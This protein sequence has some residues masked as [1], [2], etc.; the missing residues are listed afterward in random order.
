MSVIVMK[1]K[2]WSRHER[3]RRKREWETISVV[4]FRFDTVYLHC[5]G[6]ADEWITTNQSSGPAHSITSALLNH[7]SYEYL[8]H[9]EEDTTTAKAPLHPTSSSWKDCRRNPIEI[10]QTHHSIFT[11]FPLCSYYLRQQLCYLM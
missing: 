1:G 10:F 11:P 5:S 8:R 3:N 7:Y 6:I 9:E 2:K 4:E